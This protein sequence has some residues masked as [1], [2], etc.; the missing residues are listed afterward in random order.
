M[1]LIKRT[2]GLFKSK[3]KQENSEPK[4]TKKKSNDFVPFGTLHIPVDQIG[5]DV[6]CSI[7]RFTDTQTLLSFGNT[8]KYAHQ[9]INDLALRDSILS[10]ML[11][12]HVEFEDP[13]QTTISSTDSDYISNQ[14]GNIL[15]YSS[16]HYSNP[17]WRCETTIQ[18]G[19]F[20]GSWT[21]YY[22]EHSPGRCDNFTLRIT[23]GEDFKCQQV[24]FNS[25]SHSTSFITCTIDDMDYDIVRGGPCTNSEHWQLCV[26]ILKKLLNL[27]GFSTDINSWISFA[28][29]MH[30][31]PYF[32]VFFL[33]PGP[34]L[35]SIIFSTYNI[36]QWLEAKNLHSDAKCIFYY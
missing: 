34:E 7:L 16:L 26:G 6:W 4:K 32:T 17:K 24:Y 12:N 5:Q 14:V 30:I 36:Y 9:L 11:L 1:K 8:C 15:L 33:E 22:Y 21:K 35:N 20:K 18:Q 2:V 23:N 19:F 13:S 25:S 29:Q 27:A 10:K 28:N 31:S 3:K